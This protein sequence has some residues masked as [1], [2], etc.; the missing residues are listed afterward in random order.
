MW[1]SLY[2]V[3]YWKYITVDSF[4]FYFSVSDYHQNTKNL[5]LI[6]LNGTVGVEKLKDHMLKS[7]ATRS[8]LFSMNL[9]SQKMLIENLDF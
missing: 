1:K 4:E 7:Y 8:A 9:S 5:N 6:V 3:P 2:T